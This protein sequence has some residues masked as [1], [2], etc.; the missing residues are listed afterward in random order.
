MP[1]DRRSFFM[2]NN[3]IVTIYV[4]TKTMARDL[5]TCKPASGMIK[6]AIPLILGN[7]FQQLYNL[8]DTII[9]GKYCGTGALAAV[10]ASG[11]VIHLFVCISIGGGI[12]SS[13]IIAQMFGARRYGR[14]MTAIKTA[15]VSFLV[16]GAVLMTA[17]IF[18]NRPILS[19]MNTPDDIMDAAALYMRIYF[20]GFLFMM[21]F[22]IFNAVFNALGD[23]KKPLI[24]LA[25][26]SILNIFLNIYFITQLGMTVDGVAWATVISQGIAVVVTLIVLVVKLR[27]MN[28]SQPSA[29]FE[30]KIC[31]TIFK[32]AGPSILQQSIVSIGLLLLQSVVNGFGSIA[33]AG[34]TAANKIDLMAI[35]P[36]T[37]MG[38]AV[39]TFTAQN[40]GAGKKERV[41]QGLRAGVTAVVITGLCIAGLLFVFGRWLVGLF[42]SGENAAAVVEEGARYLQISSCFYFVFG[43]MNSFC[44]VLRGAGDMKSFLIAYLSNFAVRVILAFLIAAHVGL[45]MMAW[46]T[47]IGW[48]C[49]LVVAVLFYRSGKWK[50]KALI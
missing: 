47:V 37:N 11:A 13:V 30:G 20:Y 46:V 34:Y 18:L 17:G 28:I 3:R 39:S 42:V 32:V 48:A 6:F 27:R 36:M 10:G 24:F 12:G 8:V 38:N 31:R 5:T 14:M 4:L 50:E 7:M 21:M 35:L 15:C 44:G 43:A 49:S 1:A 40:I 41:P 26:S 16:I 33:I 25:I 45:Y 19:L 2:Y 22:N 9:V 29:W 23:S